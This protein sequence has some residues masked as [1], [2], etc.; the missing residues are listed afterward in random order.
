M[1]PS[2]CGITEYH[3]ITLLKGDHTYYLLIKQTASTL[4]TW[5]TVTPKADDSKGQTTPACQRNVK[6]HY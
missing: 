3:K 2:E 4:Q 6:F 5:G 1:Q